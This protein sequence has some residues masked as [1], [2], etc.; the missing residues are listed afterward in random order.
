MWHRALVK[1]GKEVAMHTVTQYHLQTHIHTHRSE[2]RKSV[3]WH[4]AL[5]KQAKEVG[6]LS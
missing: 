3:A 4:R 2:K 1:Q 5:V 6:V